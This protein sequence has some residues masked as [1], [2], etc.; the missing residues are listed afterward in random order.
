MSGEIVIAVVFS[1]ALFIS[2]ILL[3]VPFFTIKNGGPKPAMPEVVYFLSVGAGFMFVELYFIKQFILLFA[4]P[5]ISFTVVLSGILVFSALGGFWSQH[6]SY[7][8]IKIALICLVIL[9]VIILLRLESITCRILT[10]SDTARYTFAILSLLPC[11]VLIGLP[12]PLGMR[13]LV[14]SSAKRAH[15]WT[16]N[17]CTSVLTSIIAA[18]VALSIGISTIMIAAAA[19]YFLAFIAVSY[20]GIEKTGRENNYGK[21]FNSQS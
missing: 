17:G 15:A 7:K 6:M 9:L 13:Y 20:A 11:G 2:L 4:N 10:L 14:K 8:G 18:Q 3:S 1:E 5:V 19:S 21:S 12:F 16:A